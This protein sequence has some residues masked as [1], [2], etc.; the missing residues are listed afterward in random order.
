[1][2]M[3]IPTLRQI[4]STL[5]RYGLQVL[6]GVVASLGMIFRDWLVGFVVQAPSQTLATI[7]VLLAI[8]VLV[9]ALVG[10]FYIFKSQTLEKAVLKFDPNYYNHREFEE[11]FNALTKNS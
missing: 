8:A 1:M 9:L 10:A 4:E 2:R 5:K 11:A 3:R 7:V 6:A